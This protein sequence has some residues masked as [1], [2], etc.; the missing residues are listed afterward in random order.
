MIFAQFW[1]WTKKYVRGGGEKGLSFSQFRDRT[2]SE[3]A[4]TKW[5]ERN[6]CESFWCY[7]PQEN[8]LTRGVTEGDS[9]ERGWIQ[10]LAINKLTVIE[11]GINTERS[12]RDARFSNW[13]HASQ[14]LLQP[15][16]VQFWNLDALSR[17]YYS[18]S[19]KSDAEKT[20]MANLPSPKIFPYVAR[21]HFCSNSKTYWSRCL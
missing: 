5:P 2:T 3:Y 21:S 11:V 18:L 12:H 7:H 19:H 16:F 4:V 10:T 20:R 14:R 8:K 15:Y 1:D 6:F 9:S 13:I 17:I